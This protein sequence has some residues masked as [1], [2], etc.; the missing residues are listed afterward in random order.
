MDPGVG[1]CRDG[2]KS[3][4]L[5][6]KREV[7]LKVIRSDQCCLSRS[8][9]W[10][11]GTREDAGCCCYIQGPLA[12]DSAA[13]EKAGS[14]KPLPQESGQA[15]FDFSFDYPSREVCACRKGKKKGEKAKVKI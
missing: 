13:S 11:S 12:V 15:C 10:C 2:L 8:V 5:T 3:G 9:H 1:G 4:G 14:G 6:Q 7:R